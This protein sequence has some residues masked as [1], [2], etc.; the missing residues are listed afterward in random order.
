MIERVC[1]AYKAL[2]SLVCIKRTFSLEVRSSISTIFTKSSER[3]VCFGQSFL[4]II[5]WTS[6]KDLFKKMVKKR[7]MVPLFLSPDCNILKNEQMKT[8]QIVIDKVLSSP[9]MRRGL[10]RTLCGTEEVGGCVQGIWDQPFYRGRGGWLLVPGGGESM[11]SEKLRLIDNSAT[12]W[13][14]CIFMNGSIFC[15]ASERL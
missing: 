10:I 9:F 1:K 8:R 11:L 3:K 13:I 14:V 15:Q 12:K 7:K 5:L 6:W 4:K 2:F